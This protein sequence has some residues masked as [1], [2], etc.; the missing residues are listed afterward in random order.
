MNTDIKLILSGLEPLIVR[1]DSNFINVGERTNVT[2]S[3]KFLRCIQDQNWEE[4][5]A[6]AREQVDGGAQIIDV[7]MD[8]AMID[9]KKAMIHFLHLLASE[10]DIAKIPVMIDSS[11]WEVIEAGLGC[12]QGKGVVNSISL[13]DGEDAFL[14]KARTIQKYGAAVIIMAFDEKGQADSFARRIEICARAYQLLTQKINFDPHD[15]IFDPNIFP[16]GTGME[17]HRNNAVDF[18]KAT[19]WIKQNLPHALVSG[20]VSNVSFSFRGNNNVREAIHSVF[21]Y[22]AIQH[23]LDMGIVNPSQLIIYDDIE[24][25]LKEWVEDLVLNRNNEAT[26]KLLDYAKNNL[27]HSKP[28]ETSIDRKSIQLEERLIDALV[29][30]KTAHIEEDIQEAIA[31]YESPLAIIE[32]PLMKGMNIVGEYFGNG[33]MFLPQVVKSAR[34]MKQAVAILEPLLLA[35]AQ[36]AGDRQRKKI[37]LATVKGDVHDIG[38]N[39][40]G[41]VLACNGYDI[42]DLGVMVPNEK[43]I[44]AA[45]EHQV[46]IIGLSGLITPSLEIMTEMAQLLSSKNLNIPLLIGGATTSKVH[47]AV[48]IDPHSTFPVLHVRDAG[49]AAQEVSYLLSKD[50]GDFVSKTKLEYERVRENYLKHQDKNPLVDFHLTQE[51]A[52]KQSTIIVAPKE[53]SK[54][55]LRYNATE[56]RPY[57]DWTPFFQTWGL[58]GKFPDILNDEIV[59]IQATELWKDAQELLDE[60]QINPRI[61]IQAIFQILPVAKKNA[62]TVQVENSNKQFHFL[63]QQNFKKNDEP[64]YSLIDFL[65]QDDYLGIFAVNA[66]KGVDEW[67]QEIA[68]ENNDYKEILI[69]AIADRLA[70]AATEKLHEDVRKKYWGYAAQETLNTE[71]LLQE[72]FQ[73]IRPAPGYPACPDHTEKQTIWEI[74]E[75]DK[76][77]DLELTESMAMY[78]T[79]AVSGYFFAHPEAKYF[80]IPRMG[81]DKLEAYAQAKNIDIKT[82]QRWLGHI[83]PNL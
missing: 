27:T 75:P 67:L 21:L 55:T 61:S 36:T 78:P 72:K 28:E 64:H 3:K 19:Q 53:K 58:A 73:G 46:D 39:I 40:V 14:D 70:E 38:K 79:A 18:F 34:V 65:G 11:K 60:I 9:A 83:V 44:E 43:I 5:I 24:P 80:G 77:I 69:K 29:Q 48:K 1:T 66:G 47:T 71:E 52:F 16:I 82:A 25:Q 74:L 68:S 22:H 33:K 12:I 81:K 20:G 23:G 56:V 13:K 57:I 10:P 4:A 76:T 54:I 31:V 6:I 49:T 8:E 62:I 35:S 42:I 50:S 37:L 59:G 17:E 26:E 32:G 2:G 15:I 41:V 45:I 51:N 30:G 7:N 63:R